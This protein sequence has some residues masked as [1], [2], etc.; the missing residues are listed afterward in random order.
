MDPSQG[1]SWSPGG[2]DAPLDSKSLS[3]ESAEGR[4]ERMRIAGAK[5]FNKLA[6]S[7]KCSALVKVS[8]DLGDIY[9]GHATWDSYTAMLRIYKHYN[10]AL[11][12]LR[13]ATQRMS[14]SSY[15]GEVFS[16]DD[17]YLMDSG[18]V[19][20]QTTNKIFNNELFDALTPHSA[21]S[22]QRIRAA[23]WL[24]SS[25][26]EWAQVLDTSNSGTYNNQYMVVDLNLFVPGENLR[27]GLL[28]VAEQIPG[29][30]VSADMTPTLALG[31]WPSYNVPFFPEV[32]NKS[33]YPDF[34]SKLEQYGQHFT[35][36]THWL[37]YETSPRAN[38]F[39]RDQASIAS[40]DDMKRVMR[41]NN[42]KKDPLAE[43]RAVCAVCGR[44]D[45]DPEF[46]EARGCYDSK[47]TSYTLALNLEAE[48][49]N[50]PT[51]NQGDLPAFQW[52]QFSLGVKG[53]DDLLHLGQPGKFDFKFERM[54]PEEP[55]QVCGVASA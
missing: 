55:D 47:V 12:E 39:R 28:W 38:I 42:W 22:W 46:P 13:P 51:R 4:E 52:K 26:E 24:A 17:F 21:L 49:V 3:N 32:Y 40:L 50:G 2:E 11:K 48:V 43:G 10:F 34:I 54:V 29:M 19:V 45:L 20:L 16:D 53:S 35:A 9:M 7:G 36:S 25:G 5:L 18:L 41:S 8:E 1:P 14:F 15:P 6:L 27:P 23:N 37:S 30:V 31:Y 33:G 44:G